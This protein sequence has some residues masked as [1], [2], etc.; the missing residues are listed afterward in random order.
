VTDLLKCDLLSTSLR[1][2]NFT[3]SET[4]KKEL[5][6]NILVSN[7]LIQSRGKQ[8]YQIYLLDM[9]GTAQFNLQI[10]IWTTKQHNT[11]A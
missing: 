9:K 11:Y 6:D 8:Q 5:R 10:T 1:P 2:V 4:Y 3:H 7:C